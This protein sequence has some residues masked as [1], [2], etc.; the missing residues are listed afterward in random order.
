MLS[1]WSGKP[2]EELV[3]EAAELMIL[4]VKNDYLPIVRCAMRE[5]RKLEVATVIREDGTVRRELVL[6]PKL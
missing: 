1:L 2:L 3:R 6:G 5:K 4:L